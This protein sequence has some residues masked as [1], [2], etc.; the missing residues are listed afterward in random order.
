MTNKQESKLKMYLALRIF[1]NTNETLINSLPNIAE[2][3]TALNKAIILIQTN[4]EISQ[5]K[6]NGNTEAKNQYRDVL[7][8]LSLENAGKIHAWAKYKKNDLLIAET[9]TNQ[10]KLNKLTDI[11]LLDFAK[12][13]LNRINTDLTS[14]TDYKLD[15]ATQETFKNQIELFENSVPSIKNTKVNFKEATKQIAKGIADADEA[16]DNLDSL[17]EMIRFSESIIYTDYKATRK[18][19][20]SRS[21]NFVFKA[22]VTDAA[23][24]PVKDVV[25]RFFD[26]N[27][28]NA[29]V[30]KKKTAA[31]GGINVTNLADGEYS[32]TFEKPG[33]QPQT[34]DAVIN[35]GE[36]KVIKI[37]LTE[38]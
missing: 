30:L 15:A 18:I 2:F 32:L 23:G 6:G 17:I 11:K 33:Y 21:N 27:N 34:A 29:E 24:N 13:L 26:K 25:I 5:F 22:L 19:D 9:K 10:T 38:K 28:G 1:L 8:K 12:G 7:E 3:L 35:S 16:I 37:Q 31:K 4:S 20:N 14:L 36:L